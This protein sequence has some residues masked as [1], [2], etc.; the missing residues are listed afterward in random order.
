[1]GQ[2]T[3]G[4]FQ[5]MML[6][7]FIFV[8]VAISAIG[9]AKLEHDDDGSV[10]STVETELE[11]ELK[12]SEESAKDSC[13]ESTC[14]ARSQRKKR[15]ADLP[16]QTSVRLQSRLI[17]P[18]TPVGLYLVWVSVKFYVRT[19]FTQS[20]SDTGGAGSLASLLN[21]KRSFPD[22][23]LVQDVASDQAKVLAGIEEGFHRAGIDGK[24]C[25]LRAICELEETPIKH[26][27]IVGDMLTTLLSPKREGNTTGL[28]DYHLAA[29]RGLEDGDCWSFY[30]SCPFSIFNIIPDV[31]TKDEEIE[32]SMEEGGMGSK[33][34][35]DQEEIDKILEMNHN[36]ITPIDI[37]LD[38]TK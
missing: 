8:L 10:D 29:D 14:E 37:D 7:L 38:L 19:M 9:Q 21:S 12:R 35:T 18:Q 15:T 17:I 5:G 26:W 13:N 6:T 31:Y 24:E 34:I 16:N 3:F 4:P 36:H 20:A 28:S 27:T 33:V 2:F 11:E 32:I 25:V 1:M 22:N 23:I 30:P